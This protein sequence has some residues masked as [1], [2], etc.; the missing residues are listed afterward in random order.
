[1]KLSARRQEGTIIAANIAV[2]LLE[3]DRS[4][5][6]A[7]RSA[8]QSSDAHFSA[9]VACSLREYRDCV[10]AGPPDIALLNMA[11]PDGRALDLVSSPSEANAFP[12]VMMANRGDEKTAVEAM[13]AG[14]LDYVVKSPQ[15]FAV[16]PRILCRALDRWRLIQERKQAEESRRLSEQDFRLLAAYHKQLN[17]IS[18]SF[19]EATGMRDLFNRIAETFRLLSGA[20]A[21]SFSVYNKETRELKVVSLSLDPVRKDQVSSVFGP[22][23]LEAPIPVSE[24]DLEDMLSRGIRRPRDLYELSSGV[25][26]RDLSD[27]LMDAAGCRQII[28]LAI[29]F[30]DELVGV[31]VA[32]LPA[33]HQVV[34]D[35]ALKTFAY[36]SGLAVERRRSEEALR[37]SEQKYRQLIENVNDVVFSLDAAGCITYISPV[38]RRLFGYDDSDMT[39]KHSSLFIPADDRPVLE[40]ELARLKD[41]PDLS[42]EFRGLDSSGNLRYLSVSVQP[43]IE[44]GR[45]K[46]ISGMLSD[47]TV[48]RR[49]EE[50]RQRVEKL[51]S[52][53]LLAGGIAHDFNNILTAILGNISL[54]AMDAQPGSEIHESLAKAEKASLRAKDLTQQLLTFAK[55]GAPVKILASVPELLQDTAGFALRG[56]SVKC[57]FS[58]PPDLWHA[59]ID[60]GQISQII[61]NLVINA[62]QAMPDGGSI[63]ISVENMVLT[64]GRSLGMSMP[65]KKGNYIRIAVQDHGRGIPAEHLARIFDPFFTTKPKGS[66][67][68]LATSFSIARQHGGHLSVESEVGC[69]STFYLYLPASLETA[70][71]RQ[72]KNEEIQPAGKV[73]ILVMDDED[74]VREVTGRMLKHIGFKDIEFAADGAEAIKLYKAA[75]E[76]GNPFTVVILDLTIPGGLGGRDTVKKLLKLDPAVR[77]VVTSGYVNES[78]M[79]EYRGYGFS[80]MVAKPYTFDKLRQ[81]LFEQTGRRRS[82][83][84]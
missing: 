58:I 40:R 55:G 61:H 19:G 28:A 37:E 43:V 30:A 70:A 79:A 8:L 7:I 18:I 44:E 59:E 46:S 15:S 5:A 76:S 3:N 39:G 25:I 73:R 24:G 78:A 21:S 82:T 66:G 1:M 51:E 10:A 53:G 23:M 48:R 62:Q 31:C 9:V 33:D 38:V 22:G 32:Y 56:S 13:K 74:E 84:K 80:G 77:A 83:D 69:G 20:V 42:L 71:S 17:G 63:E 52:V 72:E 27:A 75:M 41:E 14:A 57:R 34:P 26:P 35:D 12:I 67:L 36:M 50:E 60:E 29:S 68:G 11:M 16:M 54:A 47:I 2:L 65:L 6:D 81:V 49:L 64:R 45:L 4:H